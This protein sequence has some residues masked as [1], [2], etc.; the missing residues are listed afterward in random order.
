MSDLLNE[1]DKEVECIYKN[2]KYS[3]RDN[4]SVLRHKRSSGPVRKNDEQW[5]FGKVNKNNGYM[6]IS[7]ER[8]HRIVATA[9]HG[10]PPSSQHIVDHIDTNRQNNR[11]DNLRW[12]T[13]LENALNNPITR[14]KIILSCGSIEAFLDNPSMLNDRSNDPNLSWM[15]TVSKE[16]AEASRSRLL[17]WAKTDEI[18][19]DGSLGEWLY[20]SKADTNK[21]QT[22][23][24]LQ[25]NWNTPSEFPYCPSVDE[26][27]PLKKYSE[28]LIQGVVFSRNTF[29]DSVV[30]KTALYNNDE[31]LLV[32][33]TSQS[34]P[35]KPYAIA[36]VTFEDGLFVHESISTFFTEEGADKRF[37]LEQGLEWTGGDTFDDFA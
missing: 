8:I 27:E 4:G 17:E 25:R 16:E 28:N 10:E 31:A 19:K 3:V 24:V 35:I 1:F 15:R 23:G 30:E 7:N 32:C 37:T 14:K 12:V 6:E 34:N 20:Q 5:T 29:G 22:E 11:V 9:F 26:K 13:K 33:T 36:K 21:S 2:E 18:P